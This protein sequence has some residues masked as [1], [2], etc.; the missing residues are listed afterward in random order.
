MDEY[1]VKRTDE[2]LQSMEDKIDKLLQFKWA[3]LGGA[4]MPADIKASR[5]A[6]R[7]LLHNTM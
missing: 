1:F 3:V 4:E 2:R 5:A 7:L 6:A